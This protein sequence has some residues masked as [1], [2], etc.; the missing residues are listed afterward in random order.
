MLLLHP[1][2]IYSIRYHTCPALFCLMLLYIFLI[3]LEKRAALAGIAF[4][5]SG[6]LTS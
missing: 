3:F 6:S 4:S 1:H 2:Y 5:S